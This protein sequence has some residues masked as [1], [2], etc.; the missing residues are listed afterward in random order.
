[1][2]NVERVKVLEFYILNLIKINQE[3]YVLQ[4]S[5]THSYYYESE[6]DTYWLSDPHNKFDMKPL[7]N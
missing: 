4:P 6:R 5:V 3:K 2:S 7:T 1:M